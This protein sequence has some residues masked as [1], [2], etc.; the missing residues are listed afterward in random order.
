MFAQTVAAGHGDINVF[1]NDMAAGGS[2]T[3]AHLPKQHCKS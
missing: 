1:C 3:S 2:V